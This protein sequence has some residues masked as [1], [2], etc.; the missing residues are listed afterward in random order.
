ME[1]TVCCYHYDWL[2]KSR[3]N[4]ITDKRLDII[5]WKDGDDEKYYQEEMDYLKEH[6]PAEYATQKQYEEEEVAAGMEFARRAS[7]QWSKRIFDEHLARESD[8]TLVVM[9]FNVIT[10][11]T[12]RERIA[13][14]AKR[15]DRWLVLSFF[16]NDEDTTQMLTGWT[17][18]QMLEEKVSWLG[19]ISNFPFVHTVEISLSE[20]LTEDY[21]RGLFERYI[22]GKE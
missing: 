12:M 11:E 20:T 1:T 5:K 8:K 6:D 19:A 9:E 13:E 18:E 17:P 14:A 21:L 16:H 10:A 3:T 2:L 22:M 15:G 4:F 7:F